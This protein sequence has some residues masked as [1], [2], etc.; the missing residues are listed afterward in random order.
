MVYPLDSITF[1]TM[2][3]K[4][5][6]GIA[7]VSI[8]VMVWGTVGSVIDYPLLQKNIY[9]AGSFGQISTFLIIGIISTILGIILF[10]KFIESFQKD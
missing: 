8:L 1:R 3:K 7:Y 4:D 10:P 2:S 5:W 6:L 9:Q